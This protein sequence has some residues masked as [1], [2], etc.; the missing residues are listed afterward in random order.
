MVFIQVYDILFQV[1]GVCVQKEAY[2]NVT[3]DI[4]LRFNS[5]KIMSNKLVSQLSALYAWSLDVVN[6]TE[7]LALN[8][9]G[10]RDNLTY[11]YT[12]AL[13]VKRQQ[14]SPS[15]VLEMKSP[16]SSIQRK[17]EIYY[18]IVLFISPEST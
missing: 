4:K 17:F 10:N 18:F 6:Q 1:F 13:V 7:L 14:W 2:T 11:F 3:I 9:E 8:V 16:T 12:T 15:E 5:N